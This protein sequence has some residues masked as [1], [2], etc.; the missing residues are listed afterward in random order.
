MANLN[1]IITNWQTAAGGGFKAVM[2][3]LESAGTINAQ[4]QSV[5][6]LWEAVEGN[7]V[8]E[9]LYFQDQE[10]RVIDSTTGGLVGSW[11]DTEAFGGAGTSTVEPV[12]D[13]TQ[14]LFRWNTNQVVDGRFLKGRTFV[15]GLAND[16]LLNGNLNAAAQASFNGGINTFIATGI[17]FSIWHRPRPASTVN[18]VARPGDYQLVEGGAVWSE[19]AVLRQRRN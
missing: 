5:H 14:V 6:S 9:T 12:A 4:R 7:L 18:P 8:T 11:T 17:G 13:A 15:P 2:Y 10:G 1:E 19:L 16:R 3:F